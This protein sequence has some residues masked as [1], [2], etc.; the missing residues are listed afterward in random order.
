MLQR[1]YFLIHFSGVAQKMIEKPWHLSEMLYAEVFVYFFGLLTLHWALENQISAAVPQCLRGRAEMAWW[2]LAGAGSEDGSYL[3][4]CS[5][6]TVNK[7]CLRDFS[8]AEVTTCAM[9]LWGR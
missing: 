3:L 1:V 9:S 2:Q 4:R 6:Y 5:L 8:Y 7:Y